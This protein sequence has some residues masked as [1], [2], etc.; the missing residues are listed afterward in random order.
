MPTTN[1]YLPT[2]PYE[3]LESP[4]DED[5]LKR[6]VQYITLLANTD[7]GVGYTQDYFFDDPNDQ[8]ARSST[9]TPNP[10]RD[11]KKPAVKLSLADYKS[12][13][14]GGRPTPKRD[15][16]EP[17]T[18]MDEDKKVEAAKQTSPA[19]DASAGK[20]EKVDA[21]R[22]VAEKA[23]HSKKNG[24]NWWGKPEDR[25]SIKEKHKYVLESRLMLRVAN[26][27][28]LRDSTAASDR[29]KAPDQNKTSGLSNGQNHDRK[30][31]PSHPREQNADEGSLS[32]EVKPHSKDM[33]HPLPPRPSSPKQ[34]EPTPREQKQKRLQEQDDSARREKGSKT[35]PASSKSEIASQSNSIRSSKQ[36][37]HEH[38]LPPRPRSPGRSPIHNNS[39]PSIRKPQSS[40]TPKSNEKRLGHKH[41]RSNVSVNSLPPLLSPL[42]ADLGDSYRLDYIG[43]G[44]PEKKVRSDV[45]PERSRL[46]ADLNPKKQKI[47]SA[48][49][50]RDTTPSKIF[51]LPG[52]LSPTLPDIVEQELARLQ[53]LGAAKTVEGRHDLVRQLDTP[54]V[55]RKKP[56]TS[57]NSVSMNGSP[58]SS[59]PSNDKDRLER[60][61]TRGRKSLLVRIS[62]KKRLARDI[63]R[64][65]A[66]KPVP[67]PQFRR[68]ENERL[69]K[70]HPG[71]IL[72]QTDE[73]SEADV[74][75]ATAGSKTTTQK[76]PPIDSDDRPEPPLKRV[77]GADSLDVPKP[78]RPTTPSM[79]PATTSGPSRSDLLATPKKGDALK[80]VAMRK[81]DSTDSHAR[82]PQLSSTSTPVSAEKPRANGEIRTPE[83]E[84]LKAE[85]SKFTQ[86]G[87]RLKRKM[88]G[89]L[90]TKEKNAPAVPEA[91]RKL[92]LCIGLESLAAYMIA[93][94]A[95]DR[96]NQIRQGSRDPTQW[97][98]FLALWQFMDRSCRSFPVLHAL[99]SQLGGI[100]RG[101]LN[102]LYVETKEVKYW[103]K[104]CQNS[105][106]RDAAWSQSHKLRH[107]ILDLV[108]GIDTLGPWSTVHDATDFTVA[109]LAAFSKKERLDWKKD[110]AF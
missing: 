33:K 89:I 109:V 44:S 61:Y 32:I 52:L 60:S 107:A 14:S 8:D 36:P 80:S 79:K 64:L 88:D 21:G 65:L 13:K 19:K 11:S 86:L 37:S 102:K 9:T 15:A 73:E 6:Q 84:K 47:S 35:V 30:Q 42:P 48:T 91:E 55:A 31:P 81:V 106:S 3:N 1:P 87:T 16:S 78:Q 99:V 71:V 40:S 66:T 70:A 57:S 18:H 2:F 4:F 12:V 83:L 75:F 29:S 46:G 25:S 93:F 76:R 49:A 98:Q 45:S 110:A 24:I 101:E 17:K 10:S 90:K 69:A 63:E 5:E 23:E 68:L 53:R 22:S 62:Y 50:S 56:K 43:F 20:V 96:S 94:H 103:D 38:K 97:E 85:E 67:S 77:K 100:S 28:S 27:N 59:V 95:R 26:Y 74:P 72:P 108:P 82:T 104:L 34:S 105:K 92:G 51:V 58:P 39:T 41:S 54:G 7:R